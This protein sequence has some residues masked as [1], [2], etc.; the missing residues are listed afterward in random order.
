[1]VW[2]NQLTTFAAKFI[3]HVWVAWSLL[4]EASTAHAHG[5]PGLLTS[6][7][8]VKDHV[9]GTLSGQGCCRLLAPL[10]AQASHAST[11]QHS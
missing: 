2:P 6:S 11:A 5:V 3:Q 9:V 7:V 10:S 8:Q 1:M 4:Q